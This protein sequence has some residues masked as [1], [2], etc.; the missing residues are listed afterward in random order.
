MTDRISARVAARFIQAKFDLKVVEQIKKMTQQNDHGSALVSGALMLGH[1]RLAEKL[2]SVANLVR[3]E[4][5]IPQTLKKYR[6]DL[7]KELMDYA[8]KT[9]SPDDYKLFYGAY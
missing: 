8:K 3:L 6:D 9:L 1:R 5:S 7:Y 2:D 4:G